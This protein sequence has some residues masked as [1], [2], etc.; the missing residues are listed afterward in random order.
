MTDELIFGKSA[1]GIVELQGYFSHIPGTIEFDELKADILLAQEELHRY[2]GK[3]VIDEA[4]AHYQSDNFQLLLTESETSG[5]GDNNLELM[6]LLV[7]KTQMAVALM[8]YREYALNNDATHTKTGRMARMDKD[9]DEFNAA[10]I[11]RDDLALMRKIQRAIDRLTKFVDD[12]QLASWVNSDM[13]AQTRDLIL[14]NATAF[15]RFHPIEYSQRFYTLLVP[16]I[17]AAQRDFVE[18]VLGDAR[19][20]TLIA[21]VKS[22]TIAGDPDSSGEAGES[23]QKLYDITGGAV[24][25]IALATGYRE[26]P[27]QLFPENMSR[28]FWNAGNGQAFLGLRDKMID[29]LQKEGLRKLSTLQHYVDSLVA[30]ETET[31]ITS[32]T[33]IN[34]DGRMLAADKFARV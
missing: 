24:A 12:N 4:I 14:W 23:L 13:Y 33:I 25:Y 2:V 34:T 15:Q 9:S 8:G 3:A 5:S 32:D 31:P 1:Q 11:D 22:D 19:Y 7:Y 10:L 30:E 21:R 18:P 28:H 16:M 17:R 27:I 29:A 6:D 20:A 26:L